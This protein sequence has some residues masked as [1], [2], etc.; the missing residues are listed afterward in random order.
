MLKTKFIEKLVTQY[1]LRIF[2]KF[3]YKI[4]DLA[5]VD[6]RDWDI[7]SHE[8]VYANCDI[9]G[10]IRYLPYREYINSFKKY[11]IYCC[12]SKC[13]QFKNKLTKKELYG[14]ENYSNAKKYS[15]TCLEKYG[16]DNTFKNKD[17]IKKI[18]RV[19][20]KKYGSNMEEIVDKMKLVMIERYGVDNISKLDSIKDKKKETYF[21]NFG[22]YYPMQSEVVKEKSRKKCLENYGVEYPAQSELIKDK[23]KK[24]CLERYGA[25]WFVLSNDHKK[26]IK[27]KYGKDINFPIDLLNMWKDTED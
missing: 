21:E 8:K 4:G 14:D 2:K 9:C 18:D 26:I 20:R 6:I 22:T 17:I 25:E 10:N 5:I 13:S 19:K 7:K 12:S 11:E 27:E 16:V 23:I 15:E 24:T 1:N 3:G